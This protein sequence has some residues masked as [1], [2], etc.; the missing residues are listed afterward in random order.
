MELDLAL[1]GRSAKKQREYVILGDTLKDEHGIAGKSE[2]GVERRVTHQNTPVRA[3]LAKFG[4]PAF[5]KGS[6]DAAALPLGPDRNGP[7]AIP[8]NGPIA[9][10]Y[11][12]ERD[13]P[14]DATSLFGD[15]RDRQRMS[16]SQG[17]DDE[18][19]GLLAE[20][21]GKEGLPSDLLD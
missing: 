3:D 6:P 14:N 21:I 19:L 15:E 4:K 11:R 5:H 16:R 8:A 7:K 1:G 20:R 12:R 10:V 13:M 2:T 9:D 18:L 17:A